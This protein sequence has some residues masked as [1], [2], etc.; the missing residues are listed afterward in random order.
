MCICDIGVFINLILLFGK[1]I[2]TQKDSGGKRKAIS[3]LSEH[4]GA[5]LAVLWGWAEIHLDSSVPPWIPR[6]SSEQWRL[7]ITNSWEWGWLA[8][9]LT[10][11]PWMALCV[12][13]HVL[14]APQLLALL[15]EV[16]MT[17]SPGAPSAKAVQSWNVHLV[18]G[19]DQSSL[20]QEICEF[21]PHKRCLQKVKLP[22]DNFFFNV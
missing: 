9:L 14:G 13:L 20:S 22:F 2:A 10:V 3:C 7:L 15:S 5:H 16:E 1:H 8:L 12:W 6:R 4:N 11:M 19:T 18:L 17:L 21:Y